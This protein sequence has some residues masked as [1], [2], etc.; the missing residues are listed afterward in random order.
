MVCA[1]HRVPSL[2]T[3]PVGTD[4]WHM[5]GDFVSDIL[6]LERE[7]F[8]ARNA[9]G[10]WCCLEH[11]GRAVRN[12]ADTAADTALPILR[13]RPSQSG[14][15]V[16]KTLEPCIYVAVHDHLSHCVSGYSQGR[17]DQWKTQ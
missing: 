4:S 17:C 16:G 7:A 6:A 8:G 9:C 1:R 10:P 2:S 5:V 13:S 15:V 14:D 3:P 12:T 11:G